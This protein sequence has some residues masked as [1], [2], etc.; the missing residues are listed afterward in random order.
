MPTLSSASVRAPLGAHLSSV[1]EGLVPWKTALWGSTFRRGY[2]VSPSL[3]PQVACEDP[4][5]LRTESSIRDFGGQAFLG[6]RSTPSRSKREFSLGVWSLWLT[7]PSAL[8]IPTVSRMSSWR[9]PLI[10]RK[11]MPLGTN[12]QSRES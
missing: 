2:M 12:P 4:W 5:A 11:V 10:Q 3:G 6:L 9:P 7:I 1:V 8:V